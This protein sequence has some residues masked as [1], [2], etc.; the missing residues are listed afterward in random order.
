MHV[1]MVTG[2]DLSQILGG[3]NH[4][5]GERKMLITDEIIGI[6]QLLEGACARAAPP[7]VNAYA[8]DS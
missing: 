4:I 3:S 8:F 1:F 2:V 7:K 5:I 6:Y